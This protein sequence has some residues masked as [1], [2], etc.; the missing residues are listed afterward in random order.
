MAV[1]SSWIFNLHA[2]AHDF[3]IHTKERITLSPH[4]PYTLGYTRFSNY[5]VW[6]KDSI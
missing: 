3:D 1:V 2:N 5:V 6:L 4:A